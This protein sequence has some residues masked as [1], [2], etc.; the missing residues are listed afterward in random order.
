MFFTDKEFRYYD[1]KDQ[2][3]VE[4]YIRTNNIKIIINCAAY[5]NVDTAEEEID[6]ATEINEVAV[7]SLAFISKNMTLT[8]IHIST[9]YVFEGNSS[10]PYQEDEYTN[11]QNV[12][13]QTKLNG[14]K[15]L[16]KINPSKF[17]NN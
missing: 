14:E 17:N 13:G 4:T 2:I 1:Y 15:A 12:Y 3:V 16:L 8:L 10:E 9:D 5:T 7:E 11:P 6:L